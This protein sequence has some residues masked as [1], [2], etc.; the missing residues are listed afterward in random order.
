MIKQAVVIVAG[1]VLGLVILALDRVGYS[2]PG[3]RLAPRSRNVNK[4]RG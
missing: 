3:P 2:Y 4:L 1:V